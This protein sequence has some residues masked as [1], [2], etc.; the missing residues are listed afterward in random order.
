MA[1]THTLKAILLALSAVAAVANAK[2]AVFYPNNNMTDTSGNII[3]AHGGAI[4]QDRNAEV[5]GPAA[6]YWFG[7][8][9][10]VDTNFDG[11]EGVSCY[12][13]EDMVAWEYL[14]HALATAANTSISTDAVVERPKVLYNAKT[15]TYVMWFHLD[16]AAYG[17]AQV[18]IATSKHVDGPYTFV[19][20]FSPLGHQ[21]RDMTVWQ[22]PDTHEGYLIFAT[23][24]NAN[25]AIAQLNDDYTNTTKV[26]SNFTNVYW[27]A[28]GV[29]KRDGVFYLLTSPQ[30]GWTPTAN[31]WMSAPSM[32]GPWSA[33][34]DLAPAGSFTYLT[35][36]AYDITINGK[37]TTTY[38]YFGDRWNGNLLYSSTYSFL[39][40]IVNETGV[41]IHNSGGWALDAASGEWSDLPFTPITAA[42]SSSKHLVTC[43]DS[44]AGGKAA[45][46]TDD[47]SFTFR[48]SGHSGEKVVQVEYTYLG[49]S[50]SFLVL[51]AAVNGVMAKESA[52]LESCM[53][54]YTQLAPL[55]L[56]LPKDATVELK[57]LDWNGDEVLVSGVQVYSSDDEDYM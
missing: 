57:L 34:K 23:D 55:T 1:L 15:A 51:G 5:R 21:S 30:N 11:F 26:V 39:P 29:V 4:I 28:P 17:L 22:D 16:N 24:N 54:N 33:A 41:S 47:N 3:Q 9:N 46:V 56:N 10:T 12:K 27:E 6:W 40:L 45:N 2:K 32:S 20:G 38:L 53:A 25:L 44:C 49:P 50:N 7:Q 35:Q 52:A 36:N 14:G 48:W 8:D 42:E 43:P 13:S 37:H 18:G 31:L 19:S